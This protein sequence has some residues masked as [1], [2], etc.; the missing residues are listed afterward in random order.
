M[1]YSE[2]LLDKLVEEY[3]QQKD[4]ETKLN[5]HYCIELIHNDLY[6]TAAH[7]YVYPCNAC[8]GCNTCYYNYEKDYVNKRLAEMWEQFKRSKKIKTILK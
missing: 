8:G 6:Y 3:H 1:D 5:L 4:I 7:Q 2:E